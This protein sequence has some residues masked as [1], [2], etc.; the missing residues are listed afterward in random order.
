MLIFSLVVVEHAGV[1]PPVDER[2]LAG[3]A[4]GLGDL[5]L[6]VREGEVGAAAMDLEAVAEVGDAHRRALDVPARAGPGPQGDSQDGSS[7]SDGCHST[8]SSGS[9]LPGMSGT[10]PRSL[11]IGSIS[12]RGSVR[13]L[14]VGRASESTLK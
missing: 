3:G 7:G 1:H 5:R 14:A 6:V 2:P 11:A 8:K 13:E 10:L 12:S 4:L 9:R